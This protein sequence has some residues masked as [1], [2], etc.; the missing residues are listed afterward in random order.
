MKNWINQFPN[1][2]SYGY[3]EFRNTSKY[4]ENLTLSLGNKLTFWN[5]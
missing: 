4:E 5:A 1:Y 2:F 3:F